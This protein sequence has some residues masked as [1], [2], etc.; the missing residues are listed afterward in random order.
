MIKWPKGH[1]SVRLEGCRTARLSFSL[2]KTNLPNETTASAKIRQFKHL[3]W[4]LERES[5]CGLFGRRHHFIWK[6]GIHTFK[7]TDSPSTQH[8]FAELC[9]LP[10]K[11]RLHI[12]ICLLDP[13]C[14][15]HSS[16]TERCDSVLSDSRERSQATLITERA[17]KCVAAPRQQ[18][19]QSNHIDHLIQHSVYVRGDETPVLSLS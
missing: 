5:Y 13:R 4:N 17:G 15:G 14:P 7:H 8:H 2:L 18:K 1:L 3:P 19:N 10:Y 16:S 12:T 11:D 6:P 9:Q